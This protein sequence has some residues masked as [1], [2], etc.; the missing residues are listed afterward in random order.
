MIGPIW[1]AAPPEVHSALLSSGPGAGPLLASAAA[2]SGLASEYT[3]VAA[4]ISAILATVQTG[5]WQGPSA[6][7]YL[8]A[9]TPYLTWLT[10]TAAKNSTAATALTAAATAHTTA[11]ATMPTLGELAANHALHAV[12]VATNFFGINM[13][14]IALNEADYVRMWIQAATTMATYQAVSEPALASVPTTAPAPPIEQ[15]GGEAAAVAASADHAAADG[16]AAEAGGHL[17]AADQQASQQAANAAAQQQVKDLL[18]AINMKFLDPAAKW[19][20]KNLYGIDGYPVEAYPTAVAIQNVL[21]QIP[22]M[23]M[24]LAP[25]LAWSIFHWS[26]LL[27]PLGQTA[28]IMAVPVLM[29]AVPALAAAGA[30]AG[31]AG[32]AGL[33]GLAGVPAAPLDV[34]A[35]VGAPTPAGA[36]PAGIGAGGAAGGSAGTVTAP[37]TAAPAASLSMGAGPPGGGPGIGFDPTATTGAGLTDSLYVAT[38][39]GASA[40]RPASSRRAARRANEDVLE[41][42]V[43]DPALAGQSRG[44]RLKQRHHRR[45]TVPER[46]YRY[47]FIE[48]PG[49][50]VAEPA[51]QA[52]PDRSAESGRGAGPLGFA[53]AAAQDHGA[54]AVGLMTVAADRGV[55][56]PMIPGSRETRLGHQ[57]QPIQPGH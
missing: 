34:P 31:T 33:A 40:Q 13:I 35:A 8:A 46:G 20:W 11:L 12:L 41:E 43:T 44:A 54:A 24:W 29:A 27:W 1:L 16:P 49:D 57:R 42:N 5:A 51:E 4:E 52:T 6:A 53:G 28:A 23:P 30:A 2:W 48:S 37:S 14:P 36:A 17:A 56:V 47:E 26:M 55:V 50:F 21:T 7:R 19:L 45:A 38:A 25:S 3:E 18:K 9:H 32:L 39:V 15:P 22:G 10:Q